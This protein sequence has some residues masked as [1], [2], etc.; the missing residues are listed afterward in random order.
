[1]KRFSSLVFV[2]SFN[3]QLFA[4][5]VVD[6]HQIA[7]IEKTLCCHFRE[8]IKRMRQFIAR[9]NPVLPCLH[10][11]DYFAVRQKICTV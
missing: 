5:I 11:V 6:T 4:I 1:M 9:G 8:A 10:S 7:V 2:L 3:R